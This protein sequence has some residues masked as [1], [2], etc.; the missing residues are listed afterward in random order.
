M[1][2]R[3]DR[4]EAAGHLVRRPD[5]GDRRGVLIE[6][7]PAGRHTIDRAIPVITGSE[8]DFVRAALATEHDRAAVEKALRRLLNGGAPPS[9]P[10]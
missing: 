2:K 4:L 9:P 6:L 10:R 5:P 3:L 7:T 8:T 1:T